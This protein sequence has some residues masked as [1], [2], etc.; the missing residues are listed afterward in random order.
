MEHSATSVEMLLQLLQMYPYH[1]CSYDV[2]ANRLITIGYP[3]ERENH[4]SVSAIG[5]IHE[6]LQTAGE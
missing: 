1:L 5:M 3:F 4:F 6:K 2:K